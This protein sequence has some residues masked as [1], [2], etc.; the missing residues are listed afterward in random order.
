M[1]ASSAWPK[2][3]IAKL[4]TPVAICIADITGNGLMDVIICHDYGPTM[5]DCRA[6]AGRISWLENPGRDG[7][8]KDWERHYIGRWPAMHRLSVGHFTQS[9]I[10]ELVAASIV[11]GP[12]DVVSPVPII[13]FQS[14]D[15][16]VVREA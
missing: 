15:T 8:G 9:S 4:D 11:R 12:Q 5:L 16:T 13:R 2:Y 7:L 10:L 14:P 6:D 1:I 3:Q